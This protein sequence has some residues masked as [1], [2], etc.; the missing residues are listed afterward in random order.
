M[1]RWYTQD[2]ARHFIQDVLDEPDS[3]AITQTA[4]GIDQD[5]ATELLDA[6]RRAFSHRDS[7]YVKRQL[8]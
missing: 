5:E 7:E 2:G 6:A 8:R 1:R 3:V 4:F